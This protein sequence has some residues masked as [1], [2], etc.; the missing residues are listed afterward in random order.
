MRY[1]RSFGTAS[2]PPLARARVRGGAIAWAPAARSCV[3]GLSSSTALSAVVVAALGFGGGARANPVDGVI[4]AGDATI[5]SSG[6][7]LTVTQT[8]S[9]A[10]IDWRG[11]DIGA[12]ETT[13][14]VQ[15][16]STSVTL[17]RVN[18]T[19]A[20]RID[21]TLTANGNIYI[22]NQNGVVFGAGSRVD[23]NGLVATTA[24]IS[25]SNFMA[26]VDRFDIAGSNPNALVANH[27]TITAKDAGLVGLV[28]PNVEN[29]GVITARL[30]RVQLA[31]GDTTTVDLYGDGLLEVAVSNAVTSQTVT[32]TGTINAAGGT[33]AI[34]A[35]A[36]AQMVGSL[37]TVHGQLNAPTVGE[38]Q[39]KVIIAAEGSNAVANNDAA[40]K[41]TKSGVST[42]LVQAKIDVSARPIAKDG[43]AT[44]ANNGEA[45]SVTITGDHVALLTGTEIDATGSV[46]GGTIHIGGEYLGQGLTPAALVTIVQSGVLLDASGIVDPNQTNA[47]GAAGGEVIVYAD[48]ATTFAG[49]IHADGSGER[50]DGGFVETSGK[51]ALLSYGTVSAIAGRNGKAGTWLLDPA[52][53]TIVAG[54]TNSN[55]TGSPNFT[56]TG[57]SSQIGADNITSV[58]N[59]GT[60]VTIT[61]TNDG[62]AGNGDIFVNAAITATGSGSLTLSAYRNIDVN[63]AITLNGGNLTLGANNT[64]NQMGAVRVAANI[65][66]GGGYLVIGGGVDPTTGYAYGSVHGSYDHGVFITGATINT[67]AGSITMRGVGEISNNDNYGVYI[68]NSTLLTTSGA[69]TLVGIGGTPTIGTG[70]LGGNFGVYSSGSTI[71]TSTGTISLNGTGGAGSSGYNYGVAING[72]AINAANGSLSI[73]GVGGASGG[74]NYGTHIYGGAVL[75]AINGTLTVNGTGG[76]SGAGGS[77]YGVLVAGTNSAIKTTGSGAMTVY[78]TAG[79]AGSGALNIGVRLESVTAIQATGSGSIT[80]TGIGGSSNASYNIG[81][82]LVTGVIQ[83]AGGAITINATGG[84]GGGNYAYGLEVLGASSVISN[85]GNGTILINSTGGGT[86][87]SGTNAGIMVSG[88]SIISTVNGSLTVNGAGGGAGTGADNYGVQVTGTNSTIKTTGTG[89]LLVNGVGG[90][91]SGSGASNYGVNV[92][93][94][95]GIQTTGGGTITISGTGG[96]SSGGSNRGVSVTGSIT[97]SGGAITING[98]GGASS[99]ASNYGVFANGGTISNSGGGALTVTGIGGGSNNSGSNYGV[100]AANAGV[101]SVVNGTLTINGTGGGAGTGSS[102]HGVYVAGT[103][104]SIRASGTGNISITGLGGNSAGTGTTNVGVQMEAAGSI[105]SVSGSITIAGAGANSGSNNRGVAMWT[106]S[107][108]STVDG[109]ISMS[110]TGGGSGSGGGNDGVLVNGTGTYVQAS[111]TGSI[112][113]T[114]YGGNNAGSA[115]NS[116]GVEIY[117]SGAVITNSGALNITGVGSAGSAGSNTGIVVGLSGVVSSTSG[118]ITISGTGGASAGNNN[119]GI[120]VVSAGVISNVNGTITVNGTGGGTGTS[121]SNY[122]VQ[123]SSTGSSIKTTGTGALVITGVGGNTSGSGGGNVGVSASTANSIQTTGGGAITVTGTGSSSSG[124]NNHGILVTGSITGSGG[125]MIINGTGGAS[126]GTSNYGVCV[127]AGTISNSGTGTLTVTG[128]G[129]GITNSATDYGVLVVSAGVISSVDGNLTVNGTGGGAGTGGSNYGVYITNTGSTIRTSGAGSITVTAIAGTGSGSWGLAAFVTDALLTTGSGSITIKAAGG[130][131]GA[132]FDASQ[133]VV[134]TS[135]TGN[136]TLMMDTIYWNAGA[137][138]IINAAGILTIATYTNTSMGVGNAS[139][140]TLKLTEAQLGYI[141]G[142]SYVFGSTTT[143]TGAANTND[144][145]V[146]TTYDFANKNVT[147]IAGRDII[148]AGNLTKATGAGTATYLFQANQDIYNSSSAGVS[149]TSGKANI[150]FQ[151]DYDGLSG[152]RIAFV[153]GNFTSNGGDITLGGGT[154]LATGYATGRSGAVEGISLTSSAAINAGA[155]ALT[156]RGRGYS[157]SSSGGSNIGIYTNAVTLSA[158]G[159]ISLTGVGGDYNTNNYGMHIV[160]STITGNGGAITLNG[161]GGGTL[162]ASGSTNFGVYLVASSVNNTGNDITITAIGGGGASGT[163]NTGYVGSGGGANVTITGAGNLKIYAASGAGTSTFGFNANYNNNYTTASGT[164]SIYADSFSTGGSARTFISSGSTL[165]IAQYSNVSMGVGTSAGGTLNLTDTQLSGLSATS[166]VFGATTTG[167]GTVSTNDL[168]INTTRNFGTSNVT[169]IAGQDIILAGNLV[170]ATGAGTATYV[171][172]ANRDIYNSSNAGISATTGA[173]NLTLQSDYNADSDGAIALTGGTIATNGGNVTMGGGSGT[174]SAGVGFAAGNSGRKHGIILNATTINANGGSIILNGK[175]WVN[176]ASNN[177]SFGINMTNSSAVSTNGSGSIAITGIGGGVGATT[178]NSGIQIQTNSFISTVNGDINLTGSVTETS[179]TA[180]AISL[181]GGVTIQTTGTG[182]INLT[183]NGTQGRG[184]AAN[185]GTN[186][187]TSANNITYTG[188]NLSVS[189]SNFTWTAANTITIAPNAAISM[190]VG[191]GSGTMVVDETSLSRMTAAS[192]IFGSTTSSDLIINTARNFGDSNVTFI[193]GQD[194]ILAT[195]LT[196]TSGTGTATYLFQAYRNIYNSSNAGISATPG[197]INLTLQSDYN[198]DSDGAIYLSGGTV[199]TNG[200]NITIG[201]GSGAI[202]AGSGYAVGNSIY[203]AGVT[204]SGTAVSAGG[205]NIIV[206]GRG[207]NDAATSNHDGISVGNAASVQT[208]GTGTIALYGTGGTAVNF[209]IGISITSNSFVRVQNGD[210][211]IVG[212]AGTASSYAGT[213]GISLYNG[214][215]LLANGSGNITVTGTA[216]LDFDLYISTG[217][218]TTS[219]IGGS[220]ATGNITLNINN[221]SW[222][223]PYT[224]I[225]T[226][227]TIT[228]RPRTANRTMGLGTGSSG[229]QLSDAYLGVLNGGSYVFGSTTTGDLTINTARNFGDANVTFISGGNIVLSGNLSRTSGTATAT[230]LFQAYGNIYNSGGADITTSTGPLNVTMQADADGNGAGY[231]DF[232]ATTIT[233]LGGNIILGGGTNIATGYAQG[234]AG[235]GSVDNGVSITNGSNL[236]AGGGNITIRGKG[237]VEGDDTNVG[238]YI[239]STLTTSGSGT[240]SITGIGGGTGTGAFSNYGISLDGATISTASGAV[241]LSGTGGSAGTGGGN[242]GIQISNGGRV[243]TVDGAITASGIGGGTGASGSN[244]GIQMTGTNSALRTTGTGAITITAIGGDTGGTGTQNAGLSLQSTNG[245]ETTGSG[246]ITINA[247]GGNNNG[248]ESRGITFGGSGAG[249]SVVANNGNIVINAQ[250]GSSTSSGS[251]GFILDAVGQVKTTGSGNITITGIGGAASGQGIFVNQANGIQATGTGSITLNG[252]KGG[253][254]TSGINL[255]GANAVVATSGNVTLMTDTI[256]LNTAGNVTAGGTI[257]VATYTNA[258]LGIG[259]TAGALLNITETQLSYLSAGTGYIF[260]SMSTAT[261]ANKTA[262]VTVDTTYDFGNK[263]VSFISG[264]SIFLN[265]TLTKASGTGTVTYLFKANSGIVNSNNAGVVATSGAANIIFWSD[266]NVLISPGGYIGLTGATLSSNGGNIVLAG[267]LDDGANGGIAGDGIADGY[268]VSTTGA[269]IVITGSTINAGGG[270]ITMQ[271]SGITRGVLISTGSAI[272]TIGNGSITLRGVAAGGGGS[273]A[274]GVNINTSNNLIQT[275]NGTITLNGTGSGATTSIGVAIESTSVAPNNV[276]AT[277]SG[278]II[279]YADS[280]GTNFYLAGSNISSATG[281]VTVTADVINFSTGAIPSIQAGN[282][283]TMQNRSA[284]TTIG[285]GSGAGTLSINSSTLATLSAA[286]YIFGSTTSGLVDVNTT[287]NFGD[288]NVTF[289]SGSDILLS[290]SLAKTSGTATAT[291]LFQAY[292]NITNSSS[293]S[294]SATSGAANITL[295]SDYDGN[296]SGAISLSGASF[297]RNGG[298]LTLGGGTKIATG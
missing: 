294:I 27:G 68:N 39:G 56:A 41:G 192:Y 124:N 283:L 269:G 250:G 248:T 2:R 258:T 33:I 234:V 109:A 232:N 293:A 58:L 205:G 158:S 137:T 164:I 32:N 101:I 81:V 261:G 74:N 35:A 237:M 277:G 273:Q 155:G 53:I 262:A 198:A 282:T 141:N 213:H 191:S 15:P 197:A 287:R 18:S 6:S 217:T 135:G 241:T 289:L 90:N 88:G 187:I 69:I 115:G 8:S 272:T 199:A 279:I 230:Y 176:A 77:N 89:A 100:Y 242:V 160:S 43:T 244:F 211:T 14:F 222:N 116:D 31:S 162:A 9:R 296:G 5:A 144:L 51:R 231:I 233:T 257:T 202:T 87:N 169:F 143:A 91:A 12:G 128:I 34:T 152:G 60:N 154:T 254:A 218:A 57:T 263:N 17:N 264:G 253:G 138:Y 224:S 46:Q 278:N 150:L 246:N 102:N 108:I 106:A 255:S 181:Y 290:G 170:K 28:A 245:I 172:Q 159:A 19:S 292:G 186:T 96:A 208:T 133:N 107:Y 200:G 130:N 196:K 134:R 284:G 26:G 114:G 228:I 157:N 183:D 215:K 177:N 119:Y 3:R 280:T 62:Y 79:S 206:N 129:G 147:F 214:G 94:A 20:S 10:V 271:G 247:T 298:N 295:Q 63:A 174:I 221:A 21:G 201:G 288:S 153:G 216:A 104:S 4:A 23:V 44:E 132:N 103:N 259:A 82:S 265:R 105:T 61:T 256:T 266:A 209:N 86:G 219:I 40:S 194:I 78:G 121:A 235:T 59:A 76:G 11:F 84:T 163:N 274:Y 93:A 1:R 168:S 243:T 275:Q 54:A 204:L 285:I 7:T 65:T 229:L 72:G 297:I 151:A 286:N 149:A 236:N 47:T 226:T 25:N 98:T 16:G 210:M 175:G 252:V 249:G 131:Y 36:G 71:S 139:S 179:N 99:G 220:T 260:G 50:G 207:W 182:S 85:T 148:L 92:N 203:N 225:Q 180:T 45:G 223:T 126:S 66:T 30:G 123:I 42:V 125:A 239:N 29:S 118:A 156:L 95:N 270:N 145:T 161:T 97:G 238:V 110:G 268:A 75:S 188:Y 251:H 136:I 276:Q 267:G 55:I 113:I 291:Y 117:S 38:H 111:G 120:N 49:I 112:S 127:D 185:V 64:G 167:N 142:A 122:G 80:L 193:S 189:G 22:V 165:T 195:N 166:Y 146:N 83:G 227:G 173:I 67:G 240:I 178:Y 24:D 70:Y 190:R 171:L 37:V 52:D 140:G 184:F 13:N 212:A 281:N 73:T 48:D